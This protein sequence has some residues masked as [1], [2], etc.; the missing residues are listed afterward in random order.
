[1]LLHRTRFLRLVTGTMVTMALMLTATAGVGV[2]GPDKKQPTTGW[3]DDFSGKK[4]DNTRWVIAS[5]QAPGYIPNYHVGYYQANHVSIGAGYLTMLLSQ[6][7]GPVDSGYGVISRGALIYTKSTYGYGTYEWRMR[8]SSTAASP[9]GEGYPTS[10]S[11]SAGF[12]Y[13]NNSQTEID[14][15]FSGTDFDALYMVNWL[16]PNPARDPTE[17]NET[18]SF[19]QPF[20]PT[21][22]FHTYKFIWQKGNISYYVDGI[23]EAVHTTN[24]PSAPAYFMINHWGTDSGNWGGTATVGTPRYFHVDWVR[25]T[26]Q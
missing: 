17:A 1:M 11:V 25:Y 3:Q 5:M 20:D 14:F 19:V 2:A 16:N 24:V 9:M 6:E 12:I 21:S 7:N 8:M 10:G 4:V 18:Y 23:L 22:S 15:E 13:V 26:P